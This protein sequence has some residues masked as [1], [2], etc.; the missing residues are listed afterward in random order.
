MLRAGGF[1][2][3]TVCRPLEKASLLKELSPSFRNIA[4]LVEDSTILSA[5]MERTSSNMVRDWRL[6]NVREA[7][8]IVHYYSFRAWCVLRGLIKLVAAIGSLDYCGCRRL[9]LSIKHLII[10]LLT[11]VRHLLKQG[12]SVEGMVGKAVARYIRENTIAERVSGRQKWTVEVSHGAL[13][14][15]DKHLLIEQRRLFYTTVLFHLLNS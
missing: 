11:Q 4:I 9:S 14:R 1:G 5:E 8:H 13:E 7:K 3:I 6:W 15:T 12:K 10:L 2:V